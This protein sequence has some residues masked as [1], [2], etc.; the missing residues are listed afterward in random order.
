MQEKIYKRRKN[1]HLKA[2]KGKKKE[3]AKNTKKTAK[4]L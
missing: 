2:R 3:E 4:T 1:M